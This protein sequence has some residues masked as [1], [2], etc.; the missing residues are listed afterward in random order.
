MKRLLLSISLIAG[1]IAAF[2]SCDEQEQTPEIVKVESVSIDQEDMTLTEGESVTLT[3]TVLPEDAADKTVAWSS[4]DENV[5]IVSSNGKVMAMSAGKTAV[6]AKSGDKSDF[7]SITVVAKPIPV[8]GIS[9]NPSSITMKVGESQTIT[10]EVTPQDAT[11][12]SVTWAS[13]NTE[14][15]SVNNGTIVGLNPGSVT[16]TA[17]TVNGG[18]TAECAVTIKANLAPSVTIGV[19]RISAVSAV[20]SGEA[21][22]ESS[23]AADMTMG[24][25]YSLNSAVLPSNSTK[26]NATDISLKQGFESSYCYSVNALGLAPNSTYYYRS[27]VNQSGQDTYGETKEFVTKDVPSILET[28]DAT[29]VEAAKATLNGKL[30]LTDVQYESMSYGF[31]YSQSE[32][33]QDY[34]L[35]GGEIA[36]NAYALEFKGLSHKTQYWYKAFVKLDEQT[37]FGGVKTFTTDVVPVS[38]LTLD[39]TEYLFTDIGNTLYVYATIL[40][41][42]ATNKTVTWA[43]D[44]EEVATVV[45]NYTSAT[46]KAVGNGTATISVTSEDQG[47]IATCAITVK[48]AVKNVVLSKNRLNLNEGETATLIASIS[49]DNAFDKE[50][51]WTSE[52]P[53]IA[54]VDENGVV[55]ALSKGTTTIRA[56]ADKGL[57]VSSS[58]LVVVNRLVASI[59]LDKTSLVVYNGQTDFITATVVPQDAS[60]Q[61]LTW[62]SSD[63]NVASVS[64]GSIA[65]KTRGTATITVSTNDGS[66]V[67]A[68]C[69]V[70]VKQYVTSVELNKTNI[71]LIENQSTTLSIADIQPS[72]A[73]DKSVSWSSSDESIATVDAG[74]RVTALSKGR[75]TITASANDGSGKSASCYVTVKR[76]VASIQLNK[77]AIT[78]YRGSSNVTETLAATVIPSS[79]NDRTVTWTSSN[80][81]V[82]TVSSSGVITGKTRGNATITVS[83]NDGSGVK[84][85]C[86]VEV[87][88]YVTTVTLS[89]TYFS[90]LISGEKTIS[91]TSVLPENA[92]DKTYTWSSSNKSVATVDATGKVT[93]KAKGNTVIKATANDG[94]GVY[95]FCSVAV[96]DPFSPV[97]LGLPSGLKWANYNLGADA[98][99]AFGD[100]YAWGETQTKYIYEWSTYKFST[101]ENGPYSKYNTS[102]Y[103]GPVDNKT[104]L[105]PEDDVVRVQL[106][107]RWRMPTNE[108]WTELLNNCTWTW[109]TNYNGSGVNGRLVK[110]T[111]GNS[112]FLPAAG[113]RIGRSVF[114][115]GA[116]CYYWSSSLSPNYPYYALCLIYLYEKQNGYNIYMFYDRSCGFSI[117]PVCK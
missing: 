58:C 114:G 70:E 57:G 8:T 31:Y 14:V 96:N 82:A 98:P 71:E 23:M 48:Q 12:K 112:I 113:H 86:D 69:E 110:A 42:D 105:D 75:A 16:I 61:S 30:D 68:T 39:K 109:V 53:S 27:Y 41:E 5:V 38:S 87:K 91:V 20:L 62:T 19:D 63:N 64:S 15:A 84:A 3:A 7:I 52:D 89:E 11:N 107:G 1:I 29:E 79:A 34:P 32:D 111:N 65:G 40:P 10:A 81:S 59:E 45:S 6:T 50:L 117:R 106:G 28:Y 56:T 17:T 90:L 9:L 51:V 102:S 46:I 18:K 74:G 54:T 55:T 24:I 25:M 101:S 67:M 99:E 73:N 95:A 94:S 116:D 49:P 100:Y 47:K 66:G 22:L 36:N 103:Y 92:N 35:I 4:A 88:Q 104:V 60:N 2:T 77:T 37:F 76:Q 93:A 43:S 72:N 80:S 78:M 26:I 97:D 44:N 83:A 13:S 33:S 21:N 85:T 108:E 115:V